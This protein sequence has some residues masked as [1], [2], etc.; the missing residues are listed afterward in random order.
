MGELIS[1]QVLDLWDR[2]KP[3]IAVDAIEYDRELKKLLGLPPA[4]DKNVGTKLGTNLAELGTDCISRQAAIDVLNSFDV[5][6][7][8]TDKEEIKERIE[9]LPPAQPKKGKWI[10]DKYGT[11][12]CSECRKP[13]RDNRIDHI[14]WCNGC[15]AKMEGVSNES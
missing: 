4:T 11:T 14:R 8:Y 10:E 12:I 6:D 9:R 15:G 7:G 3:T 5:L 2:Y 1:R 13:R